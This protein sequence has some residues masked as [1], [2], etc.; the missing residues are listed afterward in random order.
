MPKFAVW[1]L[2][3]PKFINKTLSVRLSLMVVSAMAILLLGSLVVMLHFSR[4]TVKAEALHKATQTLEGA[5]LRIDNCLL[6]VEQATGNIYF[7]MLPHLSQAEM[8]PVFC[9]KLVEANP[10]IAF[11]T[12]AFEPSFYH[13]QRPFVATARRTPDGAVTTAVMPPS[14]PADAM[15]QQPWYTRPMASKK[16]LWLTPSEK[17]NTD[18]LPSIT[19][20]LPIINASY[21]GIGVMAVDVPVGLFSQIVLESKPSP[22]SYCTLLS[23][24]GA[25]IVHPDSDKLLHHTVFSAISVRESTTAKDAAEAMLSGSTGYKPFRL[26]GTDYYVFFKPFERIAV[27]G[28]AMEELDWSVGIVYPEDDIFGDYNSLLNYVLA[29]AV[30]GLL[31]LFLFS[32]AIIHR[33]LLP[34]RLLTKSAQRIAKGNYSEIIPDSH[35]HDEIGRLQTHFKQMQQS[36]AANIGELEQL[37][38][39]LQKRCEDLHTAYEKASRANRMKT[40]FL[41]NMTDQMIG[42][43]N[44]IEKDVTGLCHANS[45]LGKDD[46][47]RLTDDILQNG[48]TITKLLNNLLSLSEEETGKEV[49]HD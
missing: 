14:A 49:S 34:L 5:V 39:T 42:P 4:K 21:E 18:T 8:I 6:S 24:D 32:R 28:R 9:G 36:L 38:A 16:P 45:S 23:G 33:Q 22:N 2:R 13:A 41:H 29:I 30:V 12:I 44:V 47:K 43:A 26:N 35:Q 20:C 10:Q 19:F 25:Y 48:D 1:M 37:T 46:A 11:C 15:L 17:M 7:A 40:A 27:T 3:V 31:L